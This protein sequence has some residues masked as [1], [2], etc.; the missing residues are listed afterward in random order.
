VAVGAIITIAS[1]GTAAPALVALISG[2]AGVSAKMIISG[3]SMSNEQLVTELAAVAAEALAAGFVNLKG[4]NAAI[5]KLAG[6]FGSGLAAKIIK[7]A[8]E[9]AIE[10]GTEEIIN[11][12]LD[13]ELY[14]GDL[15]DFAKGLGGR[16][17]KAALTGAGA[18]V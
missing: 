12:L 13:P 11:A 8:L 10:S 9:E 1:G 5:E 6:K 16:V 18:A 7:E 14:K 15:A 17:A 2:L 4:V 3:A